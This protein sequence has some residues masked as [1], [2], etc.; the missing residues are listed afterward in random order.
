MMNRKFTTTLT[1]LMIQRGT[2]LIIQFLTK[3]IVNLKHSFNKKNYCLIPLDN[4]NL[5]IIFTRILI[6]AIRHKIKK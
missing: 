4:K 6:E 5:R 1:N 2:Q 3:T